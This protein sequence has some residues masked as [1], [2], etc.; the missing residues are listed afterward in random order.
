LKSALEKEI[1]DLTHQNTNSSTVKPELLF[2]DDQITI[3]IMDRLGFQDDQE[4]E[5]FSL[6]RISNASNVV[7]P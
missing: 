7:A 6:P 5:N 3:K 1:P 2:N 4:Y